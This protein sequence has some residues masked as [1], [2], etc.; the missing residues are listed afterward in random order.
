MTAETTAIAAP[1]PAAGEGLLSRAEQLSLGLRLTLSLIAGGC[2]ILSTAITFLVPSQS[3]VAE[4]VAGIA[5]LLV[6][7]PALSAAW[8]SLRYPDL[9]GIT[10][11]L[12]ALALIA[13]WAA[14]DLITAALLPLVMTL[15]HILEERSLLGSQEAIRALSKLTQVKT[16]RI[17]PGGEIEEVEA[18][19]LRAGDLIDLRAGDLV[20]ADGLVESGASSVD[21][22]S[23][24]G[25]SVP[26]EVEPG[27]EVFSGTINGDGHLVVKLTRVGQESTLGRVIAL[28]QEA[29]GA[30]PPVTRLLERY[31]ERYMV[32]VLLIAAGTW[33]A[34]SNTVAALAVLVAS[35]PC[36]L[37]LAAPATSIAAIAVASRHGILVKGAAF[38][39]S[40]ATVDAVVFDKTGT[41]TVGQLQLLEA[42]PEPGV[43]KSALCALG[44]NLASASNHPVSRALAPLAQN[45]P[46]ALAEIKESRGL[47]VVGRLGGDVVGLGRI[48]LFKDLGVAFSVP[49]NH[50]GPIVGVSRG[51]KFL[52]WMLLADEPRPEAREAI[53]DLRELGLRRQLLLTGD[54]LPVAQRIA[55]FLGLPSIRAEALPAQKMTYVLDEISAGYRPMVVGDGIN[56]SLAL[57]VG[58]VGIAMGARGTDV[59]LASADLVLM[60]NDLRRLGTC[61]RLSRRC[62]RTIYTNVSVGLGWTVVIVAA[63]AGGWLGASGAIIAAL[64]HN[65]STIAVMANAGRLLK[66]QEQLA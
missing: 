37:V 18:G 10:D 26:V 21:T 28:L 9:H 55:N 7:V 27:S 48:E 6:A 65:V 33:F 61:I 24:T 63:A 50:D 45:E 22:A 51:P 60:T 38:L 14:G 58:A 41:V 11:Q 20:P 31:A 64:L 32:L 43:E 36:A 54:R 42:R 4:L 5:A 47:G 8:Q 2:L 66:F 34:T 29:E 39:E 35:C 25:E 15:G 52:G 57:K 30:K 13:A 1:V 44:G 62:R 59:A 56:D 23:I 53:D 17:R 46:L 12:I 3:D 49:P 40:L 16:R 19:A